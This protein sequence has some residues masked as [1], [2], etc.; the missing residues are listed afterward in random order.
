V[1]YA[2]I[3]EVPEAQLFSETTERGDGGFGFGTGEK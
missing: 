2:S 1:N 3:E